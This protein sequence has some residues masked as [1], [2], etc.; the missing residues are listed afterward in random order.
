MCN[1]MGVGWGPVPSRSIMCVG[2]SVRASRSLEAGTRI[3]IAT[4]GNGPGIS[5]ISFACTTTCRGRKHGSGCRPGGSYER[6][7]DGPGRMDQACVHCWGLSPG[8]AAISAERAV[9]VGTAGGLVS[10]RLLCSAVVVGAVFVSCGDWRDHG[11]AFALG[12][13]CRSGAG[14]LW[15]SCA[16]HGTGAL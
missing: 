4:H 1:W 9:L 10:S 13:V 11:I 2:I 16:R 6:T 12:G 3:G 5:L 15:I 7:K 14:L 8:R